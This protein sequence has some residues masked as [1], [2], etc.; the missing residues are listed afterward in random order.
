M[1][2]GADKPARSH[3]EGL[4]DLVARARTLDKRAV[5]E[6]IGIFEDT[7]PEA[8]ATRRKVVELLGDAPQA[9]VVGITGTPGSGKSSLVAVLVP[10]LLEL[11][12]DLTV[13]VLAVDPSSHVSRG[14][15][16]GDRTRVRFATD[17][18]R[19]F[20][21]SQ[22]SATELGGLAPTSYQVTRLLTALFDLVI[23]ETVGIGQSELDI[24]Y[25]ADHVYLVIQPLGGD[26]IQY[27]KAGIIEIPDSFILNKWDEPAA[28]RSYHQ[29]VGSLSLARP[30]EDEH[31]PIHRTSARTGEGIDE[32]AESVLA[33][34]GSASRVDADRRETHFFG[35]WARDEWGR[36]G[37]RFLADQ[38]GGV[39]AWLAGSDGYEHA[40]Q[41]L[42]DELPGWLEGDGTA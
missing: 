9:T 2:E 31:P 25:L 8:V 30:F 17:E 16:L 37:M 26:E 14:S 13:A 11:D 33:V 42:V 23:V 32:L 39:T 15:L 38:P 41:R 19:A 22:A 10:R 24:R 4:E 5:A 7:R 36:T 21:R 29:L 6:L 20:F 28:K 27:L 40:Q 35:R 3:D 18:R 12:P 34:V 1:P